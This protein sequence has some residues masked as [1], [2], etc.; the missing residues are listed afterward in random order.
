LF[1]YA[2]TSINI[3]LFYKNESAKSTNKYF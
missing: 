2:K 3:L 1:S